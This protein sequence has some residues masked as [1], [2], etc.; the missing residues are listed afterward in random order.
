MKTVVKNNATLR[1]EKTRIGFESTVFHGFEI[2]HG[3]SSNAE[4][5]LIPIKNMQTPTCQ[6]DVRRVLGIFVQSKNW[7]PN[8]ATRT[9]PLSDLL[10]KNKNA[11]RSLLLWVSPL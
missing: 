1:P 8:C 3:K 6:A 10:R 2:K 9:K 5:N 4:K 7:V 11:F